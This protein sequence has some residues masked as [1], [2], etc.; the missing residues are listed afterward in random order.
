MTA[1]LLMKE[2][3]KDWKKKHEIVIIFIIIVKKNNNKTYYGRNIER[4]QE[5]ARN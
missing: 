1:T 4:L 5:K 2:T 3:Q